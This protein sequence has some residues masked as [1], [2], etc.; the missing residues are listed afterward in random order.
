LEQWFS[1]FAEPNVW[2][3]THCTEAHRAAHPAHPDMTALEHE[4]AHL[5]PMPAPFDGYIEPPTR[6]SSRCLMTAA[7]NRYSV[8]CAW[9]GHRASVRLY[10]ARV[11]VVAEQ[12]VVAEHPRAT[13][14]DYV[15]YDWQHYVPLVERKPGALRNG[16]P[17]RGDAGLVEAV[18]PCPAVSS[19]QT[20]SWP[21]CWAP[22]RSMAW[23]RCWWR[24]SWCWSPVGPAPSMC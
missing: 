17:F 1:S 7:R 10:P 3:A 6:V 14:R 21:R 22:S 8:P 9:A 11:I 15:V 12:Q 18:E 5:M 4:Q 13:D 16:A 20:A 2:L 23:T 19:G 24:S